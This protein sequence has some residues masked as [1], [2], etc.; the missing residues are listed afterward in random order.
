MQT[1]VRHAEYRSV[2]PGASQRHAGDG[3][4]VGVVDA[5][6]EIAGL[7][8]FQAIR[9]RVRQRRRIRRPTLRAGDDGLADARAAQRDATFQIQRLREAIRAGGQLDDRAAFRLR[10][11]GGERLDGGNRLG[12]KAEGEGGGEEGE[13]LML[14]RFRYFLMEYPE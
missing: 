11:C 5:A 8:E 14:H 12:P 4:I 2:H 9:L 1:L 13:Q 3:N 6:D 7:V 10:D